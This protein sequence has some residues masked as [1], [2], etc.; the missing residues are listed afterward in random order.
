MVNVRSSLS[1]GIAASLVAAAAGVAMVSP[2]ATAPLPVMASPAVQLSALAAALPQPAASKPT[3]PVT[4]PFG[5]GGTATSAGQ[6]IINS[7]NAIQP[8][9][10]YSVDLGAWGVG[11]MPFPVSLAAPQMTIGYSGVEPITQA[12]VYSVAYA[13]DGKWKLIGPTVKN[14]V[15]TAYANVVRGEIGW[16]TSYFP[17][18][19]PIGGGASLV[20]PK[21]AARATAATPSAA[22]PGVKPATAP[23]VVAP[24]APV[25]IVSV[26][27]DPAPAV[28]V[29]P[30]A[31]AA[32]VVSARVVSAPSPA[33]ASA[34]PS[35]T[36]AKSSSVTRGH[37][38][39]R[40]AAKGN[41]GAASSVK[42]GRGTR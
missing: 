39:M 10:Q 29:L 40:T 13:L 26:P 28:E 8:W 16:V 33:A 1:A 9:A 41:P 2:V 34:A 32:P 7:Y 23:K 36:A 37:K 5:G 17:P 6:R 14:G 38:S 21:V 12:G 42:A 30:E 18:L 27:A 35:E 15:D 20:T 31:K 22:V 25:S 3:K 11:F 19:P 24:Q 4:G